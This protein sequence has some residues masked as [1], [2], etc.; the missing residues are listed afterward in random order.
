MFENGI[1]AGQLAYFSF[2]VE[3]IAGETDRQGLIG[4]VM[5]L[6]GAVSDLPDKPEIVSPNEFTLYDNYPNPFNP[7]TTIRYHLPSA[8]FVELAIF[9]TQGR[10]LDRLVYTK[11]AAGIHEVVWQAAGNASGVYYYR[12]KTGSGYSATKKLMILK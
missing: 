8:E 9:T 11:Q 12:L 5:G 4:R 3:L 2:A 7:S 10:L 1:S 6:F